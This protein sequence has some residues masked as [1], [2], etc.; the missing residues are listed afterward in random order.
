[1]QGA[2]APILN[3]DIRFLVQLADGGRRHL[4]APQSLGNILHTPDG[5]ACQVHLNESFFHTTFPAAVPLNNGGLKRDPFELG[6]LES[7]VSG[8]GGEVPAIVAAAITLPLL[9][10]LVPG[11]LGQLLRLG[12]QQFIERFLHAASHQFFKLPLDYFLV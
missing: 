12:F 4:A 7:N 8:S 6:H 10:A 2:V 11:S 9:I 3:V 1:M 5:Y